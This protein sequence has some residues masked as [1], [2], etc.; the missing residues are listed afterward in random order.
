LHG[1]HGAVSR[2]RRLPR[3][4]DAKHSARPRAALEAS[5]CRHAPR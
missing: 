4:F 5:G 3:Q 2:R 1:H